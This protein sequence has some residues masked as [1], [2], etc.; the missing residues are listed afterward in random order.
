LNE[1]I[2]IE[3]IIGST[4]SVKLTDITNFGPYDAIIPEVSGT[5]SITGRHDFY[6]DPSD[7]LRTGFILR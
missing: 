5:A 3:S 6:F 1:R 7:P 2:T 4:M